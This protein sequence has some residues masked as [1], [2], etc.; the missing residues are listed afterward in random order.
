MRPAGEVV[1]ATCR[2]RGE[3]PAGGWLSRV[4]PELRQ[5]FGLVGLEG[6]STQNAFEPDQ[7]RTEQPLGA[8]RD[9]RGEMP[10]ASGTALQDGKTGIFFMLRAGKCGSVLAVGG[11]R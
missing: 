9:R 5:Q 3:L 1:L 11:T 4:V 2:W 10:R 6:G 7:K 8:R